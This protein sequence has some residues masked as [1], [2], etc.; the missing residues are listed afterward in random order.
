MCSHKLCLITDPRQTSLS[1]AAHCRPPL[2]SCCFSPTLST[3]QSPFTRAD[4][5][6]N[7]C[8]GMK[9]CADLKTNRMPACVLIC[10]PQCER[11]LNLQSHN[12]AVKVWRRHARNH[13]NKHPVWR[14]TACWTFTMN[15][16]VA[17]NEWQYR[18]TTHYPVAGVVIMVSNVGPITYT[19]QAAQ[20]QMCN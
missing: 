4:S 1:T 19:H 12:S 17:Q 8:W 13:K 9:W 14:R 7:V 15:T 11:W 3:V 5:G 18:C 6:I 2:S 16:L 10:R 20:L